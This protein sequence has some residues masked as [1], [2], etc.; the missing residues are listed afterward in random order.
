MEDLEKTIAIKIQEASLAE[1]NVERLEKE[2][3]ADPKFKAWTEAQ[4]QLREANKQN[5]IFFDNLKD[6]MESSG[7]KSIKGEWG[8]ITLAERQGWDIDESELPNKFFKKVVDTKRITDTY[9][10]EGKAPK[11]ATPRSTKYLTKRFK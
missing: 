8:S 2:L 9:R 1:K 11:G 3:S 5:D 7:T 4:K 6:K 10:L